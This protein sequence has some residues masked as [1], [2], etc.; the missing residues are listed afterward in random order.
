MKYLVYPDQHRCGGQDQQHGD[1]GRTQRHIHGGYGDLPLDK[2][3]IDRK[4]IG[5][6]RQHGQPR[7]QLQ[8]GHVLPGAEHRNNR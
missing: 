6:E 7:Q 8:H 3:Y 2:R 5:H 4:Q 1:I